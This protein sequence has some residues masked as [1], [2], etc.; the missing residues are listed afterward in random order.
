M[1]TVNELLTV[2]EIRES[3]DKVDQ[4]WINE[5]VALEEE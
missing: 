5:L 4:E 3:N 1:E 2:E